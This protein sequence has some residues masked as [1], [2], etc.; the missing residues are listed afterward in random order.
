MS[1][2]GIPFTKIEYT[3]VVFLIG[4]LFSKKEI[5]RLAPAIPLGLLFSSLFSFFFALFIR[6]YNPANLNLSINLLDLSWDYFPK[7]IIYVLISSVINIAILFLGS[8]VGGNKNKFKSLEK[9]I[10]K[11]AF[12]LVVYPVILN[13]IYH[14]HRIL[15]ILVILGIMNF[16]T[17][18]N[19]GIQTHN[20]KS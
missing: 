3:A 8:I 1:V 14:Y 6:M 5:K 12:A 7:I 11:I 19:M 13:L 15:F 10:G 9:N 17:A 4:Y 16:E 2:F 20:W 18:M